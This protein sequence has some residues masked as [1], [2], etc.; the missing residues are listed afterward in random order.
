M[1]L[2]CKGFYFKKDAGMSGVDPAL[3]LRGVYVD[4]HF[5][6]NLEDDIEQNDSAMFIACRGGNLFEHNTVSP[7]VVLQDLDD[8]FLGIYI[9]GHCVG[10]YAKVYYLNGKGC[11]FNDVYFDLRLCG[12]APCK[13]LYGESTLTITVD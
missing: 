12:N 9:L 4:C 5:H 1:N 13:V 11:I 8:D 7:V 6:P 2:I 3:P 10:R